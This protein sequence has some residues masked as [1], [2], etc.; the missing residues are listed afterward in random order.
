MPI[1]ANLIR[2]GPSYISS[3][4][5]LKC[6]F[7]AA[8]LND[9]GNADR[10]AIPPSARVA[11]LIKWRRLFFEAFIRLLIYQFDGRFYTQI[12]SYTVALAFN[13]RSNQAKDSC[14]MSPFDVC[15]PG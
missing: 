3:L 6:S 5:S 15:R 1:T 12:I 11:S 4:P 9:A 14:C 8:A 7:V 13:Q 2:G 10:T